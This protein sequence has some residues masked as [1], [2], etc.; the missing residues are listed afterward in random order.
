MKNLIA[1]VFTIFF[2]TAN[3]QAQIT[4]KKESKESMLQFL[5]DKNVEYL[6]EDIATLHDLNVFIDYYSKEM[7]SIPEAYFFNKEGFRVSKKYKGTSCGKVIK[8]ADKINKTDFDSNDNVVDWLKY[9]SFPFGNEDSGEEY[10]AYVIITWAIFAESNESNDTAFNWY[11][12]LKDN[13]ELNIKVILLNL[14]IQ[15]TWQISDEN[16]KVLG[17]D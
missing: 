5:N 14:D 12:S 17:L 2:V 8:K 7:L 9:Y 10:D 16:A 1:T 6:K 13:K 3:L 4:F 11:K 15:D